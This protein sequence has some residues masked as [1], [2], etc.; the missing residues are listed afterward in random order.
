MFPSCVPGTLLDSVHV[1]CHS[2]CKYMGQRVGVTG[3]ETEEHRFTVNA[4]VPASKCKAG[5]DPSSD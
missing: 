3:E 4:K 2:L 1:L 5:L